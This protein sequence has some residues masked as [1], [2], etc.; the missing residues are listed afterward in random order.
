[1]DMISYWKRKTYEMDSKGVQIHYRCPACDSRRMYYHS[2][3][4]VESRRILKSNRCMDCGW[5][6]PDVVKD[7]VK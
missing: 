5:E 3:Y 4:P 7:L 6:N 2:Q 1:M